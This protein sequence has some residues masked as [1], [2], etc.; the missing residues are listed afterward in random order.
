MAGAAVSNLLWGWL[1]DRFGNRTVVIGTAFTGGLAPLLALL[2]P[3]VSPHLFVLV[4]AALGATISGMRLGYSNFVLEMAPVDLRPTC[5]ALQNT[6][7]APVALM[8]LLVG[9]LIEVWSYPVLL[10]GGVLL[11]AIAIFLGL[12]LLDPR[13]GSEGACLV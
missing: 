5:V 9:F 7:L 8:P 12:R 6:M 10:A 1:G 4:F 11:M 13:H 3:I 2:A